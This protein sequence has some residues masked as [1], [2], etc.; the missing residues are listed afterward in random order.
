MHLLTGSRRS[1]CY[2]FQ[3]YLHFRDVKIEQRDEITCPGSHGL[4][5]ANS[6][7]QT[8]SIWL[9]P[10]GCGFPEKPLGEKVEVGE[11]PLNHHIPSYSAIRE[12]R[13]PT[14]LSQPLCRFRHVYACLRGLWG[15]TLWG[16][17]HEG[18]ES[19]MGKCCPEGKRAV[20]CLA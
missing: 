15:K 5:L 20:R 13:T 8:L 9:L 6:G 3:C 16:C 12:D 1:L 11:G 18:S 10:R 2:N 19:L 17:L 4:Y 7:I 14:G